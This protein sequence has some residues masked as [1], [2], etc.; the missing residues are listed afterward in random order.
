MPKKSF[1]LPHMYIHTHTTHIH[2]QHTCMEIETESV[3]RNSSPRPKSR[4]LNDILDNS[5]VPLS[6]RT[7]DT[8][9]VE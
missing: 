9:K 5:D 3:I 8:W 4:N 6:L 7:T 1:L 2:M